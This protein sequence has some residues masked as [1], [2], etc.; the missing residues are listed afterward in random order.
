MKLTTYITNELEIPALLKAKIDEAII[1]PALTSRVGKLSL[2]E[3]NL[4]GLALKKNNIKAILEWDVLVTE[5]DFQTQLQRIKDIDLTLFKE[6]RVSDP[7]IL[8]YLL[9]NYPTHK[10]QLLLDS[11]AYHNLE[12]IT[13]MC[14]MVGDKLSRV[15]LSL[16]LSADTIR[17]FID[18]LNVDVEVLGLGRI[19]LFYTPRKLVTPLYGSDE[20]NYYELNQLPVEVLAS[21]EESAHKGFPVIENVHGTFMYNTKDHCI[22]EYC[23]ELKEM[24]LSFM[25]ID[26]RFEK[27]FDRIVDIADLLL[28]FSSEKVSHIKERHSQTL[29]RGFFHV[30]KSDVLFKKLK[31]QRIIRQDDIYIGEVI[32]VSKDNYIAINIRS[33]TNSLILGQEINITTPEGKVKKIKVNSMKNTSL[34]EIEFANF[35]DIVL[36][37]HLSGVVTKSLIQKITND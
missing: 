32:D 36:I 29:I 11:G 31:N 23:E 9:K 10:I 18:K 34:K 5:N 2:K 12:A 25:R 15:I 30:N 6:I 26:L 4:L 7:G 33:K 22:L 14:N 3:A 13:L 17:D 27:D 35:G 21:S 1:A 20:K 8:N 28:D 24:N 16:E 19:L 37:P